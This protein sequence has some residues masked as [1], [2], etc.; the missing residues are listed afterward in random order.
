MYMQKA[1]VL[2]YRRT[3]IRKFT[4]SPLDGQGKVLLMEKSTIAMTVMVIGILTSFACA[5]SRTD[6]SDQ[7]DEELDAS[8]DTSIEGDIDAEDYMDVV[9][10]IDAAM[11][12]KI[13]DATKDG[14]FFDATSTEPLENDDGGQ[15]SD[16]DIVYICNNTK[17]LIEILNDLCYDVAYPCKGYQVRA[18]LIVVTGNSPFDLRPGGAPYYPNPGWFFLK[19]RCFQE[20]HPTKSTPDINFEYDNTVETLDP[21]IIPR[22]SGQI[23]WRVDI[24][25][26]VIDYCYECENED[27]HY[28]RIIFRGSLEE[29]D[30]VRDYNDEVP[31]YIELKDTEGN[32]FADI[33]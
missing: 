7:I 4:A 20:A 23:G 12:M 15:D 25:N 33:R 9:K 24:A 3:P 29:V 13:V 16:A 17:D 18:R 10:I 30:F 14:K 31:L 21:D 1:F 27:G 28:P 6:G 32:L 22:L 8:L 11:D 5:K 19:G 26:A 2:R